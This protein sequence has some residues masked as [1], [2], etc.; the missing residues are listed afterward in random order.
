MCQIYICW[1]C[2]RMIDVNIR[3]NRMAVGL[4]RNK[5]QCAGGDE[6]GGGG[7][8]NNS[9]EKWISSVTDFFSQ[10]QYGFL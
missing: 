10:T 2:E 8:G 5:G 1:R 3:V 4:A 9:T 7:Q 6:V